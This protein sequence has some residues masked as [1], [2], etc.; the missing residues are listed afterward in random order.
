MERLLRIREV[1]AA[2]GLCRS[3]V[4]KAVRAKELAPPV[5]VFGR[6][7]GWKATDVRA[8]VDSRP[9]ARDFSAIEGAGE[10]K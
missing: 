8:F 6:A 1:I 9:P 10:K 2:T 3:D 5:R 4:Y 7:V